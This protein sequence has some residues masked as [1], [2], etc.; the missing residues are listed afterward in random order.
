[1]GLVLGCSILV[2][3]LQVLWLVFYN[4]SFTFRGAIIALYGNLMGGRF[5]F[6]SRV[7]WQFVV[8]CLGCCCRMSRRGI[9]RFD[10]DGL[11][12]PCTVR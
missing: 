2:I 10:L 7:L 3:V 1:M 5:L 6:I 12:T 8:G 11:Y 4:S 9:R